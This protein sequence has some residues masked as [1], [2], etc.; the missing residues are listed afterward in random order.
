MRA[1]VE[2]ADGSFISE[3]QGEPEC[4]RDF[5]DRCGGCLHCDRDAGCPNNDWGDHR[6]VIYHEGRW[7]TGRV[8]E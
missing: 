3:D 5:C 2:Q 4:G 7:K 6:W 8:K 1:D